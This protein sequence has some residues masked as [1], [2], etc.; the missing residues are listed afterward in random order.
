MIQLTKPILSSLIIA[1]L[2]GC[3]FS[4]E[5]RRPKAIE[6]ELKKREVKI[7]SDAEILDYAGKLGD[8]VTSIAQKKLMN[9]LISKIE[10][11]SFH[12]AVEFCAA[13]AQQLTDSIGNEFKVNLKRLSL[14]NRNP[15]NLP[16]SM[17]QGILEAYAY[18]A[19]QG[20]KGSTNLQLMAGKDSILYNK[21]I[22]IA[23]EL[24]LNCHGGDKSVSPKVQETINKLYPNDQAK[25]FELNEFRGMWSVRMAK[26]QLVEGL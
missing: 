22:F 13:K 9:E 8:S 7:V 26:K 5:K 16:D 1:I 23:S 4:T 20:N 19:K 14:R 10:A 15:L 21:P 24:C 18:S 25:G 11:G 17:E 12:S 2:L 3:G 6:D